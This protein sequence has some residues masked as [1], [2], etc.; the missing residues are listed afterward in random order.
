[1]AKDGITLLS[2]D[3]YG[4]GLTQ[5]QKN[6]FAPRVGFAYEVSSKLVARGGFG[7]FYNAFEN[8]GYGPNIG[9][10]YPF[11]YNFTYAQQN[12]GIPSVSPISAGTPYSGCST[13]G[14]GGTATLSAGFSCIPFTPAVVNAAQ[15]GLQGIQFA[16][17]TPRTLSAN[18]TLQYSLTRAL[19]AQVGYVLTN[20]S[21]LQTGLGNNNVSALLPAGASTAGPVGGGTTG[22]RPFPDFGQN[23]SYQQTIGRSNYS[24]LQTKL[25]QQYA[26]GLQFLFA[27]TWSKTLSDA[28]DLLNG[29]SVSGYRAPAV[30]GLGPRFDWGPADFDLR[31]V[32][33]F[34][35]GY[36]LPL[37][38]DK[39]FLASSGKVVNG[40][41]GGWNINWIT[42]LQGGQP[43][44]FRCPASTTAG[45][46]CNDINV[47]GQSQQLGL[48][49][50]SNGKLNWIG[51]PKAFQQP[52]PL[53]ATPPAGCIPASGNALLGGGPTTLRG[54]GVKTF[55]FSTLKNIPIN[56]R[57]SMQFRAE[58]FN[59]FNHPTFNAPNFGGNGVVAI[60]NS[61]NF[62]ST[63][64]GEIGSTRF[65]PY[66]PRQI[67]FALKLLY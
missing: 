9:E 25:E 32:F 22:T 43:I 41:V 16:Y 7:L 27:Y 8:Q 45:T 20:G 23:G 56:E 28:G 33:H 63:A 13:A 29:G 55:N 49:K 42:T 21:S 15:L 64:F 19:S 44:T 66:D 62:N 35:G 30:P 46:S 31:N 1:L 26:N 11:V 24:G 58:F 47:P 5:N 36:D 54:P 34:S 3:K 18:L 50:D 14:P 53:G 48:H 65:A 60:S 2:T 57:F 39:H 59:I 17:K 51:N 6:N 10:N 40:V 52:C 4:Q 38:K 61:N 37:G 67:Q 12:L